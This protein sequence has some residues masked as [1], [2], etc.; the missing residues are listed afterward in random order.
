MRN[1]TFDNFLVDAEVRE[2]FGVARTV[3]ERRDDAPNPLLL[4]GPTRSGKTHLLYA[5]E[6][7]LRTRGVNALRLTTHDFV[8]RIIEAIGNDTMEDFRQSFDSIDALLLDDAYVG[9]DRPATAEELL[10]IVERVRARGVPVVLTSHVA[11]SPLTH[12]V[13]SHHGMIAMLRTE[14]RSIA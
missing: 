3:A 10:L 12:W 8:M 14:V 13:E 4:I 7:E 11:R 6:R 5:I 9:N 1:Y 2:A